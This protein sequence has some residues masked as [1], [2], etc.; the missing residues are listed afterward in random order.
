MGFCRITMHH[1]AK[2]PSRQAS[3]VTALWT[4]LQVT[5]AKASTQARVVSQSSS[6]SRPCTHQRRRRPHRDLGVHR[7]PERPLASDLVQ[8]PRRT[9]EPRDRRR[10]DVVGI[11]PTAVRSSAWSAPCSP[12]NTTSRP[13]DTATLDSTSSPRAGRRAR[14]RPPARLTTPPWARPEKRR[15]PSGGDRGNPL[16]I[17]TAVT[18]LAAS[19]P[20]RRR[21]RHRHKG[22]LP[23]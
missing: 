2:P 9:P 1:A 20:P 16:P 6:R 21:P 14:S 22:E 13:K 12:S 17:R 7:L 19:G 10:T 5:L 3:D 15:G 18:A 11:F 4:R 23:G 8:Q